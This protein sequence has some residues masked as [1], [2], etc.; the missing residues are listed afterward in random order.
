M[1]VP[2]TLVSVAPSHMSMNASNMLRNKYTNEEE[3][4]LA[5]AGQSSESHL[6]HSQQ[7]TNESESNANR[8]IGKYRIPK[9]ERKPDVVSPIDTNQVQSKMNTTTNQP[10]DESNAQI[11]KRKI[12]LN[13]YKVNKRVKSSD[14][15][16]GSAADVDMR[17]DTME[18]NKKSSPRSMNN[19]SSSP[20]EQRPI[21]SPK[22]EDNT[23]SR[24]LVTKSN[25]SEPGVKKLIKKKV[26]WA[27]E[28]NKALVQT[29]FFEV[30]RSE[31]TDMHAFARQCAENMSIAQLEKLWERDLRKQRSLQDVNTF[32]N[33]DK[34]VLPPLPTLIRIL[35]PHS[36]AT[37]IVKSQERVVQEEREKSVLQALFMRPF[38]PDSPSEPDGDL[39]GSNTIERSIPKTI[40]LEDNTPPSETKL[41]PSNANQEST[42]TNVTVAPA[43]PSQPAIVPSSSSLSFDNSLFPKVAQI[44][45]QAKDNISSTTVANPSI[46]PPATSIPATSIASTLLSALLNIKRSNGMESATAPPANSIPNFPLNFNVAPPPP[47]PG[48]SFNPL[49]ANVLSFNNA[50]LQLPSA[51]FNIPNSTPS[52]TPAVDTTTNSNSNNMFQTSTVPFGAASNQNL[53]SRFNHNS[54]KNERQNHNFRGHSRGHNFRRGFNNNHP[55]RDFHQKRNNYNNNNNNNN[56]NRNGFS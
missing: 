33:N 46:N 45:A 27:D 1:T 47:M 37:P 53:P 42:P 7:L 2:A 56:N 16:Q 17:M 44:L 30:D 8:V 9:K 15:V 51:T 24:D 40:P 28:K 31:M 54:N 41:S 29:S 52:A 22:V 36:I 35:L 10:T 12:S 49:M 39:L 6:S 5:L 55:R 13:D 11:G 32:D 25:L 14:I 20:T 19:T 43:N 21:V 3:I 23:T 34:Q 26:V 50:L 38:L 4:I 18:N 48:L